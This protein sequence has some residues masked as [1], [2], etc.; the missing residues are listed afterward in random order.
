MDSKQVNNQPLVSILLPVYNAEAYLKKCVE[1]V[2]GQTYTNLQIVL[3][4]DGSTDGSWSMLQ[5]MAAHDDRMDIFTQS[6]RGVAAT[7]N[8]LLDL[9]KGDFILF[10]DSDDWIESNTVELL[11]SEYEKNHADMIVY[12]MI[13]TY[14][15]LQGTFTQNQVIKLFLEHNHVN[16]SLCNKL[17]KRELFDKL[18][19][20]ET[21]SYGEDALMVW[22]VLQRV[23]R[24][25]IIKDQL[26]FVSVN[27]DSLS[28][29]CFNNNK[30]SAYKVWEA[31][32]ND[33]DTHWQEYSQL[34]HARYACEM[35][36]IL[37]D[38]VKSG[39]TDMEHIRPLQKVLCRDGS[40]IT[41]T[42]VSTLAMRAF[43]WVAGHS[44]W[45]ARCI[46]GL[47]W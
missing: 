18:R 19:F 2:A 14:H 20:D 15:D 30:F 16:G 21:I 27:R 39:Y 45:L 44:Y 34:A 26:Y 24:V 29:Q 36:L 12:Q 31:I 13:D 41:S 43:A 33:V 11:V 42:G 47:V 32:C 3:V 28:R 8:R 35:T 23:H 40:Y 10:V 1:S 5:E 25:S 17:T 6:N 4:N 37:R 46:S 9:A 7:R 38:A 22:Q